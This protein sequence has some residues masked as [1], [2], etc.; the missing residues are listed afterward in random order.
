MVLCGGEDSALNVWHLETGEHLAKYTCGRDYRAVTCVDYHPYDHVLA[1]SGFGGPTTIRVLRFNK[2]ASNNNDVGLTIIAEARG[3]R[4][5]SNE[6]TAQQPRQNT[7]L[8][9]PDEIASRAMSDHVHASRRKEISRGDFRYTD[10]IQDN[11]KDWPVDL[12]LFLREIAPHFMQP[13]KGNE[14]VAEEERIEYLYRT[15]QRRHLWNH[16]FLK[17]RSRCDGNCVK[18]NG[19]ALGVSAIE[20][21]EK[22][23]DKYKSNTKFFPNIERLTLEDGD[24]LPTDSKRDCPQY[25]QHATDTIDGMSGSETSRESVQNK[26]DT[27]TTSSTGHVES[28]QSMSTK[29]L[30]HQFTDVVIDVEG[31]G[32]SNHMTE[33][34]MSDSS[35]RSDGTFVITR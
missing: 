9:L 25:F 3:S 20:S 22:L 4:N 10:E 33:N 23:E 6:R 28:I 18:Y 26:L 14:K 5:H 29:R 11:P 8:S 34:F 12:Q 30:P 32:S 19:I 16:E 1:Y 7:T 27:C 15:L 21:Q 17:K 13:F 24:A 2:S 35:P 31:G